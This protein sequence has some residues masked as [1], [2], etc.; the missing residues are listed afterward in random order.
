MPTDDD[1]TKKRYKLRDGS[2]TESFRAYRK[3][4][5]SAPV[6]GDY[7]PKTGKKSTGASPKK[8]DVTTVVKQSEVSDARG[9]RAK[10]ITK[11]KVY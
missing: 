9:V 4:K 10:K 3:D 11:K 8:G 7:D 1:K 5:L 2:Y 6:P